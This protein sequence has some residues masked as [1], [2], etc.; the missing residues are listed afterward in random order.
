[1]NSDDVYVTLMYARPLTWHSV[2]N[3]VKAL[4][5]LSFLPMRSVVN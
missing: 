3:S 5:L 1:M 4:G 2:P